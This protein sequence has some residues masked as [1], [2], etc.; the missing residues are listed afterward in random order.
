M[1]N[2]KRAAIIAGMIFLLAA[3]GIGGFAAGKKSVKGIA[4]STFYAV[5]EQ[6][7]GNHLNIKG[8]EINDINYRGSFHCT[9]ESETVLEWRNTEITLEDLEGGDSVSITYTGEVQETS[10]AGLEHVVKIQLLDDEVYKE[11]E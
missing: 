1:K 4:G 8:L 9:V 7:D 3:A 11:E 2:S 6:I 5:I 10:P